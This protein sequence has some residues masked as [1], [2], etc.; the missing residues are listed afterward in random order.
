[1]KIRVIKF[2]YM[3]RHSKGPDKAWFQTNRSATYELSD[4][5]KEFLANWPKQ[6]ENSKLQ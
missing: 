4:L 3:R 6:N 2:R 5:A 1:M